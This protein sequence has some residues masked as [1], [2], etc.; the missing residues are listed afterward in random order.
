MPLRS[1]E[2]GD[3]LNTIACGKQ[4]VACSAGQGEERC[5]LPSVI[6]LNNG[7]K[8]KIGPNSKRGIERVSFAE[9]LEVHEGRTV[10]EHM[11]RE[12]DGVD[13]AG[14]QTVLHGAEDD[15]ETSSML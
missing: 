3:V 10:P 13:D 14:W 6:A 1:L 9:R 5:Q 2:L 4:D 12:Q 15:A 7:L 11:H 8:M